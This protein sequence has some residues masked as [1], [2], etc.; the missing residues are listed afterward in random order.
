MSE[1]K[2]QSR[3][4]VGTVNGAPIYSDER[5]PNIEDHLYDTFR[6]DIAGVT[7]PLDMQKNR[8]EGQTFAEAARSQNRVRKAAKGNGDSSISSYYRRKR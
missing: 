7:P 8:P 6:Y 2:S 1:I 3:T 5:S 4:K